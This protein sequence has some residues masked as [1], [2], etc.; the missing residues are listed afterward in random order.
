[1]SHSDHSDHHIA[2]DWPSYN[3]SL[4]TAILPD[5]QAG[6]IAIS[7][8][9]PSGALLGASTNL[10]EEI[11]QSSSHERNP[12]QSR[13]NFLNWRQLRW[14]IGVG[15]ARIRAVLVSHMERSWG[16]AGPKWRPTCHN[17]STGLELR[18]ALAFWL[19]S[20]GTVNFRVGNRVMNLASFK[21]GSSQAF[22]YYNPEIADIVS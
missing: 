16:A 14:G 19:D 21:D 3:P 4:T 7:Q 1:M 15:M 9:D 10:K 22:R 8:S 11:F 18:L 2:T 13:R 5:R 6:S 17:G 20:T 12:M